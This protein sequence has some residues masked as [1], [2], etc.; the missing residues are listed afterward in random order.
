MYPQNNNN[1]TLK[2]NNYL[3]STVMKKIKRRIGFE[4]TKEGNDWVVVYGDFVDPSSFAKIAT[5][6]S[7]LK[8]VPIL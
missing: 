5:L 7:E 2:I 3:T 8:I 1:N 6:F 4:F